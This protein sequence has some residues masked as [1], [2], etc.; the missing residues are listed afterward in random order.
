M[1]AKGFWATVNGAQGHAN[2]WGLENIVEVRVASS[3]LEH[4]SETWSNLDGLGPAA[5]FI[6]DG[7]EYF[8]QSLISI[9]HIWSQ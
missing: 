4:A 9:S 2:Y 1:E 3:A 8:N 5:M 6:D 7:L